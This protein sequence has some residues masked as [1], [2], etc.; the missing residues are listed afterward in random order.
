MARSD[1]VTI[2]DVM[3]GLSPGGMAAE[4]QREGGL[5]QGR[6]QVSPTLFSLA[7]KQTSCFLEQFIAIGRYLERRAQLDMIKVA[8]IRAEKVVDVFFPLA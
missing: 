8:E 7:V 5:D 1:E 2:K 4:E 3:D 6:L